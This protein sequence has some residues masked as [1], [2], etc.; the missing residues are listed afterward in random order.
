MKDRFIQL[1]EGP[2]KD[3]KECFLTITQDE[4]HSKIVILLEGTL[5]KR[6]FEDWHMGFESLNE[7]QLHRHT[8]FRNLE[9][10]FDSQKVTNESHPALIFLKLF[11]DKNRQRTRSSLK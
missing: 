5:E 8:G 2:E 3:V 6:I 4:R 11:Y 10:L 1:L 7:E 9:N